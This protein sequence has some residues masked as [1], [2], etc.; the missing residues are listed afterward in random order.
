MQTSASTPKFEFPA[1]PL[2]LPICGTI[3]RN[4][5]FA[6][7]DN[8]QLKRFLLDHFQLNHGWKKSDMRLVIRQKFSEKGKFTLQVINQHDLQNFEGDYHFLTND[9]QILL[10]LYPQ[11]N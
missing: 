2:V 5:P 11:Q 10:T 7:Q 9:T 6:I 1:N 4:Q 3:T 8:Q